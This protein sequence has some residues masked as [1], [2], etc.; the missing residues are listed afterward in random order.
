MK[1]ILCT[2]L[3]IGTAVVASVVPRIVG[4]KP[5]TPHEF[6]YMV[7]LQ[8][9]EPHHTHFCGGALL[10]KRWVLTAGHC[11]NA[12]TGNDD[13]VA[14]AHSLENPDKYEQ[15]RKALRT[16]VHKD[17]SGGVAPHDIGLIYVSEPFKFNAYVHHL[18]LPSKKM[19]K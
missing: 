13:I 15:R 17:Y 10:N 11:V 19:Y 5:A 8:W 18:H 1:L 9:V 2:I 7:S 4:G 14:G 16:F 3:F 12:L 6:P